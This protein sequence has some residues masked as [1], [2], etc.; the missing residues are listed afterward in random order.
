MAMSSTRLNIAANYFG[1]GWAALM[2]V[3]FLPSYVQYLGVEAYGLIGLFAVI[4]AMVMVL[5]MGTGPTLN[6]EMVRFALGSTGPQY[7]RNLLRSMEVICI[8]FAAV[9]VLSVWALSG[10]L[11][12]EWL[13][14][15]KLQPDEV[16]LVLVLMALAAGMRLCE[17]LYRGSLYGL[18][19][20]IW[21][22]A[23]FAV[24]STLR[25]AGAL[26]VLIFVSP[27]LQA[28][29]IWQTAISMLTILVLSGR[30][31]RSLP[32]SALPG[33]FSLDALTSIRRF[34][35]GMMGI[36]FLT[37][38]F[39]QMDK[40][41]LSRLVS[42]QD[43][44]YYSLAAT[45]ANV[46]F[47]MVIPIAQAVYPRVVKLS[48]GEESR[49]ILAD[50]YHKTAQF[51]TVL[52]ASASLLLCFFSEGVIYAWSGS[53]DLVKEISPLLSVLV[54]GSFL[55]GLSYLPSQVQIAHGST[56]FLVKLNA[57]SL[58]VFV[59]LLLVVVPVHG[60]QGAAWCWVGLNA[61]Y[62]LG[63]VGS[64][65]NRIRDGRTKRSHHLTDMVLPTLAAGAALLTA[66]YFA[67]PDYSSRLEW[68]S[69]L[70]GAGA[71][72]LAASVMAAPLLRAHLFRLSAR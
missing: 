51:V 72:A 16:A 49:V 7:I 6:R 68:A 67:P 5:D 52:T 30:V 71:T 31:Y 2:A 40:L 12:Q 17:G 62:L 26:G 15:S 47:M 9:F 48:A 22:N 58:M 38:L 56:G 34:A 53:A 59:P 69:F 70:V 66:K 39:L 64:T 45:A 10:Y 35:A 4:Q 55:N 11:S 24:L 14:A 20:Q 44:G 18:E 3:A 27:T 61:I 65:H 54:L 13:Q 46:M 19:H 42:L 43:L 32:K 60:V 29:F 57:C 1:Q 8:G 41:L 33:H 50:L 25:Y 28:F 63:A 23:T 37:M 21:Y 36:A